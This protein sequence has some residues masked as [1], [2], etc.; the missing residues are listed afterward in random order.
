[1]KRLVPHSKEIKENTKKQVARVACFFVWLRDINNYFSTIC[2]PGQ[3][4]S[5]TDP[6]SQRL[7]ANPRDPGYLT[8]KRDSGITFEQVHRH[9]K[10]PHFIQKISLH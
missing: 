1:M 6:G 2:H 5:K 3:A 4:F 8:Q 7:Q 9:E 10:L